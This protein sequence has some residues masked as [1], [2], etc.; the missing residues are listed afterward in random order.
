MPCP[1]T[2]RVC[3]TPDPAG[4]YISIKHWRHDRCSPIN[5][6]V[7]KVIYIVNC[8]HLCYSPLN[9][10][11]S[12]DKVQLELQIQAHYYS[13]LNKYDSDNKAC[14]RAAHSGTLFLK[15]P[16]R[17]KSV[18]RGSRI[19]NSWYAYQTWA[20][21]MPSCRKRKN[22][23]TRFCAVMCEELNAKSERLKVEQVRRDA[24]YWKAK[25]PGMLERKTVVSAVLPSWEP[26]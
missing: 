21:P 14:I 26:L 23:P 11:D 1:S 25:R 8:T 24:H 17:C 2:L 9:R 5:A 19:A 22:R 3:R 15:T 13:L 18:L 6:T 12:E 7:K 10:Y 20:N 4:S 16:N